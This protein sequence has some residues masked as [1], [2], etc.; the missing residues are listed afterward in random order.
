MTFNT[1]KCWVF[2][3]TR[4]N[5]FFFFPYSACSAVIPCSSTYKYLGVH[6]CSN[7]TWCSHTEKVCAKANR[8]LAFLRQNLHHS[9]SFIR[10]QAFLTFVRLQSEYASLIW[11]A[12]QQYLTYKVEYIQNRAAHF[13][14]SKYNHYSSITQMRRDIAF[15]DLD[16]HHSVTLVITGRAWIAWH[17][18][19]IGEPC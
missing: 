19:V 6:L 12:H 16:S 14:T 18:T 2:P 4:K 9:P 17:E 15:P 5:V 13:I 11:S 10:Q 1:S 3:F 7:L 8:T